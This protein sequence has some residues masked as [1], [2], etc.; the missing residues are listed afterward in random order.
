MTGLRLAPRPMA[1]VGVTGVLLY[2]I[3]QQVHSLAAV[4][5]PN[6]DAAFLLTSEKKP[7]W[8]PSPPL[9]PRLRSPEALLLSW[10]GPCPCGLLLLPPPCCNHPPIQH[11]LTPPFLPIHDALP[12]ARPTNQ[13]KRARA[14]MWSAFNIFFSNFVMRFADMRLAWLRPLR[15]LS[16][17]PAALSAFLGAEFGGGAVAGCGRG[18][19]GADAAAL[20]REMFAR[21]PLGGAAIA[22][23]LARPSGGGSG[24]EIR[25]APVLAYFGA[26]APLWTLLLNLG[27]YLAVVHALTFAGLLWLARRERR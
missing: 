24:C 23:L 3:A 14:V 2:M 22:R 26:D 19:A 12:N 9:S 6:E 27:V 16:A 25:L 17:V 21:T 1:T 8:P 18:L 4:I 10:R 13:S 7:A 11:L 20:A 5:T 15:W